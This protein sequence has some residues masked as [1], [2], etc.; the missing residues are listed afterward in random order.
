MR[1]RRLRATAPGLDLSVGPGTKMH[2]AALERRVGDWSGRESDA[3]EYVRPRHRC[4]GVQRAGRGPSRPTIT[5]ATMAPRPAIGFS[6]LRRRHFGAQACTVTPIHAPPPAAG[7]PRARPGKSRPESSIAAD[8]PSA[9]PPSCST[10]MHFSS[11][12]NLVSNP[13]GPA[14]RGV[15]RVSINTAVTRSLVHY[16]FH[17]SPLERG[18]ATSS[19]HRA[20]ARA[21]SDERDGRGGPPASVPP[22]RSSG[23][24]PST[25][26]NHSS[27]A[28]RPRR[29]S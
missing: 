23:R 18:P 25:R 24:R 8:K 21:E 19:Q 3:L 28:R 22:P 6:W 27:A 7:S 4:L 5:S 29:A 9:A 15:L 10:W 16:L 11:R 17:P 12:A 26:T 13:L 14:S 1:A 2:S 20:H